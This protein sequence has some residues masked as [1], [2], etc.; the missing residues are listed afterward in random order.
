MFVYK[1]FNQDF[2]CNVNL[3]KDEWTYRKEQEKID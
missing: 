2:Q 3:E 1:K